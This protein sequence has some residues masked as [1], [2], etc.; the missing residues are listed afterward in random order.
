M[1]LARGASESENK[2]MID[3]LNE[4]LEELQSLSVRFRLKWTGDEEISK[5][6][7]CYVPNISKSYVELPTVGPVLWSQVEWFEV[8][9]VQR[10]YRGRLVKDEL[11]DWLSQI[12]EILKSRNLQFEKQEQVIRILVNCAQGD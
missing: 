11:I 2:S 1:L 5:W 3:K 7:T 10:K 4:A 6:N 9:T 8:E 12:E